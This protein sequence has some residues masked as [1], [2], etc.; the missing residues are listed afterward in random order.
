MSQRQRGILLVLAL[1]L[2]SI[3]AVS[4]DTETGPHTSIE[5]LKPT[6][7]CTSLQAN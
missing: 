2:S 7:G 5:D 4:A 6:N 3:G 1:L